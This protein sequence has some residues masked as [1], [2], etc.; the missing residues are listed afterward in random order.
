MKPKDEKRRKSKEPEINLLENVVVPTAI[1]KKPK[2]KHE[3]NLLDRVG[4]PVALT[5]NLDVNEIIKQLKENY[6]GASPEGAPPPPPLT[7]F[8]KMDKSDNQINLIAS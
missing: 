2:K 7:L 8:K 5:K 3:E 6:E 4:P 1:I